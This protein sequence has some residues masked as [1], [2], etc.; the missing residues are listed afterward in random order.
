MPNNHLIL[1]GGGHTHMMLLRR[2]G[3]KPAK[4]P[5]GRIT[6]VSESSATLY[7]GMIPAHIARINTLEDISVD[8][9][10]LAQEANVDFIQ[11]SIN[12][13]DTKGILYLHDRPELHYNT[14]S[15]NVGNTTNQQEYKNAIRIK[16]LDK[17]LSAITSQDIT[18]A[19]RQSESFHI[20]GSGLAA[21]EIAFALRTRWPTRTL[22]L[23]ARKNLIPNRAIDHLR[24]S[25]ITV[26]SQKAPDSIN[27]ILCTG[28][29]AHEWIRNSELDCDSAGRIITDQSLQIRNCRNHFAVGDCAVIENKFRP[30]SGVWAV[31]SSKPLA[32]NIERLGRNKPA[33]KWKP[34]KY[35]VQLVGCDLHKNKPSAWLIWGKT[36]LGPY[37]FFWNLKRFIDIQFINKLKNNMSASIKSIYNGEMAT[38]NMNCRGCGA[39]VGAST[40]QKA[41]ILSGIGEICDRPEDAQVIDKSDQG[42]TLLNSVDG[43]PALIP[44]PWLNGRLT[45]LHASSDIWASGARV[46]SSQA[47]VTLPDVSSVDQI[48][49][50]SQTL[51]GVRSA[52]NEQGALLIGGHTMESRKPKAT[53]TALDLQLSLSVLGKTPKNAQPWCKGPICPGDILFLSRELGSGVIFAGAMKGACNPWHLDKCLNILS[54]S[55]HNKI[56]RLL[57]LQE[58]SSGCINACTDITGFGL[59]G[60]LNEMLHLSPSV[61]IDLWMDN[62]PIYE[63][64]ENY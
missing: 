58:Q 56:D 34:Q 16:P 26:S 50:L 3:M 25:G 9:R 49:I 42:Y 23:H 8:I 33:I 39:K 44:D 57:A 6:L 55:Q 30:S 61:T 37:P 48:E 43:F 1:A 22:Y 59:L 52:L 7:S 35:A 28:S 32:R 15:I 20:V 2:W 18:S 14:I 19:Y 60:H 45:A 63:E 38:R 41:L 54:Q 12:G 51:G 5:S 47:I 31:R 24:N 53:P 17:A 29:E 4:R 13:I 11:A 21:M 62:I 36:W 64:L 27:T 10:W 40:L 46:I